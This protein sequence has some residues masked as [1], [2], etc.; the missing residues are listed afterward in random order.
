MIVSGS[1]CSPTVSVNSLVTSLAGFEESV[2]LMLKVYVP[3]VVGV[4]E[5]IPSLPKVRPG[6]RLPE[7]S[8]NVYGF[9]C[10]IGRRLQV[11]EERAK[12]K[13][14]RNIIKAKKTVTL[15][16]WYIGL[17]LVVNID[18]KNWARIFIHR[19]LYGVLFSK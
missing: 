14:K 3:S 5:I 11:R 10:L 17:L 12:V 1:V 8:E 2:I 7:T 15:Q 13:V 9:S 16:D 18:N 4:P 19:H 6:G